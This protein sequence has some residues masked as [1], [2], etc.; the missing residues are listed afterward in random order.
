VV[1]DGYVHALSRNAGD[2]AIRGVTKPS[3]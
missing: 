3:S 2:A 1:R